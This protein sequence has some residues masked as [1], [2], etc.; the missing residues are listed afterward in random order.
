M[1]KKSMT[2][3]MA[4]FFCLSFW[5]CPAWSAEGS[6][7]MASILE[8]DSSA[9]Q[10]K[11]K[12]GVNLNVTDSCGYTPL[13]IALT[14][15][16]V[17]NAPGM[18]ELLLQHGAR[19]GSGPADSA[20]T[21]ARLLVTQAPLSQLEAA[22]QVGGKADAALPNGFTAFLWAAALSHDPAVLEAL[23]KA[24][25]NPL[26]VLPGGDVQM[27]DNALLLAA[28]YNR[29]PEMIS[30]LLRQGLDVNSRSSMLGDSALMLACRAN[31]NPSVAETL[32][33]HG[34]D[35][36][37]RNGVGCSAFLFAARRADGLGLLRLLAERGA[38]VRAVDDSLSNALHVACSGQGSPES[39]RF[40]LSVGLPVNGQTGKDFGAYSPLMFAVRNVSPDAKVIRLLLQ[41]GADPGL[42]D[43]D[44]NRA[45]DGLPAGRIS[46]LKRNGLAEI[47]QD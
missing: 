37:M 11:L 44:G 30:F 16:S 1:Q 25:A 38:D 3:G 22:L 47:L 31:A 12:P 6:A 34:A 15:G 43:M 36:D 19:P 28:E 13:D 39:I 42:R 32:V 45:G 18:V 26:Q 29:N 8:N 27:G 23:V 24:G 4:L 33:R 21:L 9:L 46:W 35:V 40:L 20:L 7:I 41:Q 17:F 5:L 2:F 10:E 14:H